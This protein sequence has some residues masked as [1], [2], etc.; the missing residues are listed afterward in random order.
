MPVAWDT[1]TAARLRPDSP[2]LDHAQ[3][4]L[5]AGDPIAFTATTL[6]E[7]SYG[8]HKATA[9]GR[10]AAGAQLRWLRDQIDAG[11]IE[12]LAFDD[13]A[14]DIA[15]ALRAAIPTPPSTLKRPRDRSK[16]DNRVAWILDIQIAATVFAHGYDL[17]TADTHHSI[18]A[19][20]LA[21]FAP[22]APSLHIDTPP[23][24]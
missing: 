14:A 21:V 10:Q 24:F 15:G 5:Q 22:T 19:T 16:P 17:L 8:L 6:K 12:V 11:L 18:I 23:Q 4:R 7:I 2:A 13:R 20:Q 9:A 3:G 1:T